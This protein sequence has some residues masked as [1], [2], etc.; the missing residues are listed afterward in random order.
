MKSLYG[1][2]YNYKYERK[3]NSILSRNEENIFLNE[4][5]VFI[6]FYKIYCI[7]LNTF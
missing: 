4:I 5:Y 7:A 2:N 1:I 6:L 3:Y